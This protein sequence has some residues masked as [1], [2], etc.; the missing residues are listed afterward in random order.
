MKV[1]SRT[2]PEEKRYKPCSITIT[3][4]TQEEYEAIHFLFNFSPLEEVLKEN[5]SL[6]PYLIRR[7]LGAIGQ[8]TSRKHD[9]LSSALKVKI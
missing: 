7:A 9:K 3:M 6:E 4:E 2:E 1:E 5:S 8:Y